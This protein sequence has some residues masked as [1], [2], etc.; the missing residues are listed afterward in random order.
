[1]LR[2]LATALVGFVSAVIV[3]KLLSLRELPAPEHAAG[4][5]RASS[6]ERTV[7]RGS[8]AQPALTTAARSENVRPVGT[9][10]ASY[11]NPP[12]DDIASDPPPKTDEELEFEVQQRFQ[13]QAPAAAPGRELSRALGETFGARSDVRVQSVECKENLCKVGLG[14]Q[15]AVQ[16]KEVLDEV[17]VRGPL[18]K[19]AT[20]V[21]SQT[22]GPEGF[23]V[24]L[25]IAREGDVLPGN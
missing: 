7:N 24:A 23:E 9:T 19:Y 10:V 25:Y 2:S 3:L 15:N 14:F 21:P 8:Y 13:A 11:K 12:T 18:R 20:M 16:A 5:E 4:D 17:V 6:L 1:M 22:D